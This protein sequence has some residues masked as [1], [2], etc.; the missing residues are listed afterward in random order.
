MSSGLGGTKVILIDPA[1]TSYP[2]D[3]RATL[4]V[5]GSLGD[6]DD[7]LNSGTIVQP[8]RSV[9]EEVHAKIN[10]TSLTWDWRNKYIEY[11]KNGKLPS[12][13]KESR[14]LRTKATR[15]TLS[16]DGTLFFRKMFDGELAICLGPGDTDY[17]LREIHKGTFGNHYGAESLVHKVIR[18][19]YYWVDMEKDTKEFVRKCYKCQSYAPMI[20]QSREQ[21][22]SVLSPWPFMK[23]VM[24]IVGPLPSAPSKA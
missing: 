23:W 9:I 21:L 11:L 4:L 14:A 6:S 20:H 5:L 19:G 15:F 8:S 18:A 1:T 13:P 2:E 24:D 3:G 16:K 10:S 12:D 22:Y 7:E 17:V